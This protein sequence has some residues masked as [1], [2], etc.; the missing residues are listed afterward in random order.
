MRIRPAP[1]LALL[2]SVILGACAKSSES[3]TSIRLGYFPNILHSQALIGM[4]RGDFER[5]F[6]GKAKIEAK[7]FNAGPLA[8]E[9]LFAGQLDICY[10]GPNPTINAWVKSR[11]AAVRIVAGASSGGAALIARAGSKATAV[12]E[13]GGTILCSPQVG[14]TQDVA[15]RAFLSDKGLRTTEKG[16][17]VTVQA[18]DN[19]QIYDLFRLGKVDGAWVPEPWASRL[20]V[21]AGGRELVD[22]RSLWPEGRFS[23]ALVVASTE[24]IKR[25][26]DLVSTFVATHVEITE[27]ENRNAKDAE[28]IV[29][30]AIAALTGAAL[31]PEVLDRAWSRMTATWD[32]ISSSLERTADNAH[33][34]GFLKD[35]VDFRGIF[36]LSALD[37]ALEARG[38]QA[39]TE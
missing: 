28:E 8:V 36:E 29:G 18:V 21:E 24:F 16:G 4:S 32:P 19:P 7:L 39:P 35:E 30:G 6:A 12:D 13:L 3:G 23:T 37:K 11:G 15:L 25:H 14:N 5:A 27:W 9:A 2:C 38:L 34:A 31:P 17:S 22:E 26:P 33:K 1:L 10:I 20:V